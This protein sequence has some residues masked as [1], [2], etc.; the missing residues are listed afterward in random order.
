MLL[1][2]ALETV[3]PTGPS[4]R[5]ETVYAERGEDDRWAAQRIPIRRNAAR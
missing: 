3:V 4:G 5:C 2:R 1:P